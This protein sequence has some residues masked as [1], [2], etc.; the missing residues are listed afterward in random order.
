MAGAGPAPILAALAR[1][2][3]A[4]APATPG[5]GS[6]AQA[7]MQIKTALDMI[8]SALPGLQ[9]GSEM[10]RDALNAVNRLSRHMPQG[11]PTAGL[12]QTLLQNLLRNTARNAMLQRVMASQ[13][14]GGGAPSPSTPVPGA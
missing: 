10:H 9:T 7:I 4:A 2:R 12:Q 13:G 8:Q 11:T 5:A 3:G 14:Q 6:Q 1:A